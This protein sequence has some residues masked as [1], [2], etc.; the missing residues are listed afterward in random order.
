MSLALPKPLRREKAPKR[1]ARNCRPRRRR[2]TSLAA[3]RRTLW[4]YFAAYVKARDGNVC[5]TCDQ[6]AEGV[7]LHAGHLF[8]QGQHKAVIYEPKNCHSQCASCNRGHRGKTAEY[9]LRF[10]DRYGVE[11]Y[12][13]LTALAAATKA[14]TRPELQELTAALR[15]G[16][17]D[18][19]LLYA[20]KYG[21]P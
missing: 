10:I 14:W 5:F 21:L 15:R 1:I 7:Y 8:T 19:E 2:K 16:G 6:P 12:L 3:A 11:E 4:R 9:T 20:E 13:R 17:A 18:F